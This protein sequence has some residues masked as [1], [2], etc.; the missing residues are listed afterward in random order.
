MCTICTES[1]TSTKQVTAKT[2]D[3]R[4]PIGKYD[5]FCACILM[6]DFYISQML[7]TPPSPVSYWIKVLNLHS[8]DMQLLL[9]LAFT[10][11]LCAWVMDH[12][13]SFKRSRD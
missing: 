7:Q 5:N 4:M 6:P 10:S 11:F 8:D 13:G 2:G 12:K 9:K 3:K 1:S